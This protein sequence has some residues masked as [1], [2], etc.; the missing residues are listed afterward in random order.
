MVIP[1]LFALPT[2]AALGALPTIDTVVAGDPVLKGATIAPRQLP[3]FAGVLTS[4]PPVGKS[5]YDGVSFSV[6]RR[7]SSHFAGT[8]AYT[9]SRTWDNSFNELFTSSLNPRRSQDAGEFFGK[10]LDLSADWS[11]SIVDIPHRF[12]ASAI[13]EVPFKSQNSF[14]NA[15][16]GGWELTGIFQA[17]SGQL[18]DI[19]SGVDSNRNGDNA[20]DRVIINPNGDR[21]V[22]SGL[23]GLTLVNGQVF[24]VNIGSAVNRDVRAYVPGT[25]FNDNTGNHIILNPNAY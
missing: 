23:V 9:W 20:G 19:Q 16:L 1:T 24:G 13:Y 22:G 5:R 18:V 3:Q 25:A 8:A 17:Q 11:P 4:D 12:V 7:L 2:A 6:N 15:L 10:G 21:N 14:V